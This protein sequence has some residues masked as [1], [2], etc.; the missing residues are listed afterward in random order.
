MEPF[1]NGSH[2]GT[3]TCMVTICYVKRSFTGN[4]FMGAICMGTSIS[5]EPNSYGNQVFMGAKPTAHDMHAVRAGKYS[6]AESIGR[7]RVTKLY[8]PESER[9]N[10]LYS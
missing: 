3:Q 5:C 6:S 7:S 4:F 1:S 10:M 2:L 8:N 9:Y